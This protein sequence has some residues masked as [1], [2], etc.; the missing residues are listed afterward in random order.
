MKVNAM[1]WIRICIFFI[2]LQNI[3]PLYSFNSS[4]KKSVQNN[5][6]S[7]F[8]DKIK[9]ATKLVGKIDDNAF[10][11]CKKLL[12][13]VPEEKYPEQKSKV[14]GLLGSISSAKNDF[15]NAKKYYHLSNKY[16][17]KKEIFASNW[18]ELGVIYYNLYKPDS[19]YFY[20]N[21]SMELAKSL[22]DSTL[23]AKNYFRFAIMYAKSDDIKKS[24]ILSNKAIKYYKTHFLYDDLIAVKIHLAGCYQKISDYERTIKIYLETLQLATI[25]KINSKIPVIYN[26]L[27][28]TYFY[29]KNYDKA[30]D[31]FNKALNLKTG[32][33]NEKRA[34][35]LHNIGM[36][37]RNI[38]DYSKAIDYYNQALKI[39]IKEK[40]TLKIAANYINLGNVYREQ[41]KAKKALEYFKKAY[42]LNKHFKNTTLEISALSNFA[43]IYSYLKNNALAEK[44]IEKSLKL[45][46][47]QSSKKIKATTYKIASYVFSKNGDYEKALEFYKEYNKINNDIFSL[48]KSKQIANMQIKYETEKI[49]NENKVLKAQELL[50]TETLAK[51]R[52]LNISLIGFLLFSLAIVIILIQKYIYSTRAKAIIE[53]EKN[54]VIQI[55]KNILPADVADEIIESGTY[56]AR[57]FAKSAVLITDFVN[58]T[59]ISSKLPPETMI[60]E[61][62]ELYS[63]FDNIAE[64]YSSERIKTIGDAYFA[65]NGLS[66]SNPYS[67]E[68]IVEL[69]L[70]MMEFLKARNKK[71]EIKWEIRVSVVSG[72][73]IGG[74][75]GID[76]YLF[77]VF[78][79]TINLAFRLNSV[80]D[81]MQLFVLEEDADKLKNIFNCNFVGSFLLKGKG[82]HNLYSIEKYHF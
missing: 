30:L 48:R 27:G 47:K 7:P 34:S 16:N 74:I 18:S 26:N 21:K 31:F 24:I 56:R 29:L 77:D 41:K 1:K 23:I 55:I 37:Y 57:K 51:S 62:N 20:L 80:C 2:L 8:D 50:K 17:T 59:Q 25:K 60:N 53:N 73:I 38:E 54:K 43:L 39:R 81:P 64:K 6:N 13:E 72:E 5:E 69:G 52:T 65:V 33:N 75:V 32:K 12:A 40:D 58:F 68:N 76:K 14:A 46:N 82:Y 45:A 35:T 42:S 4:N 36:I 44:Y 9:I 49:E 67:L 78:G 79:N 70:E 71:S 11:Y 19:S 22:K 3:F 15:Y 66:E 10:D 61:L 28:I 63:A